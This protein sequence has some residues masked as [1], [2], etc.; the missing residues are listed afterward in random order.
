MMKMIHIIGCALLSTLMLISCV[1][2]LSTT[3]ERFEQQNENTYDPAYIKNVMD[4]QEQKIMNLFYTGAE[5]NSGMAYNNPSHKSVL[6]TGATGF[7]IMTLIA[8]VERGW[9]SRDA[10]AEQVVKIVRFLKTADR[11]EGAWAHWYNVKG[12]IVPF[13]NQVQAGEIIETSF[14]MAGLLTACEYFTADNEVENEIRAATADFWNT[15]NWKHYIHNGKFYWIWH[16]DT[17]TY[18]LPIVGWN[19]TLIAYILAMAAPAEHAVP[20]SVYK[21]C[22]QKGGNFAHPGRTFYD[23]SLPLGGNYGNALFLAHY[24]FFGMDP[25]KMEDEYCFYWQQNQ[26][27]T[28]INRHYCVYE[29][30][31]EHAY[32]AENWGL[33]ACAGCGAHEQYESRDPGHDDGILSPAAALGSF[34]YT[35]FYATQVMLNLKTKYPAMNGKYGFYASWCPADKSTAKMYYSMEHA[36]MAIMLENYRSGLL[37]N[38][39]MKNQHIQKGLQLAGIHEPTNR[40]GFYLA[41]INNVTNSCDLMRNPDHAKYEIDAFLKSGG[42]ATLSL[43]Q[44]GKEIYRTDVNVSPGHNHILFFDSSI[45]RAQQYTL[46]LTCGDEQYTLIVALH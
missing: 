6:T 39:L 28:L 38:L 20:V 13:G 34:P 27:H 5:T 45:P 36:P 32:N 31:A 17:D 26:N 7:G 16:Q 11:F 14:M 24:S 42:K 9:I 15:I 41:A 10:A 18:E 3:G 8:G 33:T 46:T 22:W 21:S 2:D 29:A 30:P 19:E 25:R 12:E 43:S 1:P 44:N 4:E 23:Y 35:P 37:W 40:F